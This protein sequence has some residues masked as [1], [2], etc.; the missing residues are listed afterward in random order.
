[1]TLIEKLGNCLE[2]MYGRSLGSTIDPWSPEELLAMRSCIARTQENKKHFCIEPQ[3]P[4]ED[5]TNIREVMMNQPDE[6]EEDDGFYDEL[7]AMQDRGMVIYATDG[8]AEF[9]YGSAESD[10]ESN[11]LLRVGTV[12]QNVMDAFWNDA[13]GTEI[14]EAYSILYIKTILRIPH[15]ITSNLITAAECAEDLLSR[16][17]EQLAICGEYNVNV[18]F[19]GTYLDYRRVPSVTDVEGAVD[20]FEITVEM[21][22]E[23][24]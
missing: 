24:Y 17:F 2:T 8:G 3:L 23:G 22:V 7:A 12:V 11:Q 15:K 13:D 14:E 9:A 21:D 20:M 5:N 4:V 6:D 10:A 1:M 19:K 18:S 16:R